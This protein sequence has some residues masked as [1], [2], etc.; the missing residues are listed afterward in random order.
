[1]R[2]L[3][4]YFA[5]L[6]LIAS[7]SAQD[8]KT[9]IASEIT[10]LQKIS[11]AQ[12]ADDEMWKDVRPGID[13]FLM[14]AN[15][16]LKRG[17]IY[18][19]LEE[20][21]KANEYVVGA[22]MTQQ[23]PE[24]AKQGLEGFEAKWKT[25]SVELV[26]LDKTAKQRDWTG[27]PAA[28]RAVG[29]SGQGQ[30]ITLLEA[31]RA[32]ASVTD[33]SAGYFYL[34]QAKANE[35]FSSFAHGLAL[36]QQGTTFKLRS[37]GA[38]LHELQQKVNAAFVPPRSI[39]KHP[40]FIRLNS[41]IK[42]AGEL[43]AAKLYAG[44]LYQYLSAV[45]QF[46]LLDGKEID[47]ATKTALP[48]QIAEARSNL[49]KSGRDNSIAEMF[50]QRAE[51]LIS[52]KNGSDPSAIEWQNAASVI[53]ALVPAYNDVVSSRAAAPTQYA[54]AVTVTLVRWPYT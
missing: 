9:K 19:A 28:V 18:F 36:K 32:Y 44:A 13:R 20:L 4:H 11:S 12:P 33:P 52:K 38:E 7:A 31:S 14:L 26:A 46:A 37:I 45:S 6:L 43:D 42:L 16:A 5:L 3:L 15:E 25:A 24:V 47:D 39:D 17:D 51:V 10:R 54:H 35:D 2:K 29:E 27:I 22:Q 1:M 34:G 53:S 49:A 40:E 21:G 50:L 41:T 8:A 30:A 48:N 23:P